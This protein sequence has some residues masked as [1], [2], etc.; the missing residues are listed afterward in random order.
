[1]RMNGPFIYA[2]PIQIPRNYPGNFDILRVPAHHPLAASRLRVSHVARTTKRA[3]T[4][5]FFRVNSRLTDA[6][7]K[8]AFAKERERE[9][10][11]KI[12]QKS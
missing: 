1:M 10:D 8:R 5:L 9:F 2:P 12:G 6:R 7:K 3:F 4:H 11:V